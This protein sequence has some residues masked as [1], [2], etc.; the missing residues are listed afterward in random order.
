[1][2][3]KYVTDD[4]K[5]EVTKFLYDLIKKNTD[6]SHSEYSITQRLEKIGCDEIDA[7]FILMEVENNF[8]V[9]IKSLPELTKINEINS[10]SSRKNKKSFLEKIFCYFS[11]KETKYKTNTYDK[12][13]SLCAP[14]PKTCCK[15]TPQ[16]ILTTTYDQIEA[17]EIKR[18]KK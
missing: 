8:N 12:D 7:E 18:A 2:P 5:Q 14:V 13:S 15:I 16:E 10:E 3:Y 6:K 9:N 1:M 4:I 17:R 11:I